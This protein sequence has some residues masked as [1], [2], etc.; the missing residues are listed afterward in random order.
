MTEENM[1]NTNIENQIKKLKQTKLTAWLLTA[2]GLFI[3]G[4][5]IY[6]YTKTQEFSIAILAP[7]FICLLVG[8]SQFRKH[9]KLE[10][11]INQN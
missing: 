8:A 3:L 2:A 6:N 7:G 11:E 4:E 9:R 10:E 1:E 5:T